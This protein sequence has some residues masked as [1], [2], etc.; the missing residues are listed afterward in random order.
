MPVR[1]GLFVWAGMILGTA[2]TMA[3]DPPA[4]LELL[5]KDQPH[6]G[7]LLAMDQSNVWLMSREGRLA[8]FELK[9]VKD[10]K[11]LAPVFQPASAGEVRDSLRREFAKEFEIAASEHYLVCAPEGK[12]RDYVKL[13]EEIYRSFRG[14]FGV[15][16][17]RVGEPEFPLVAIVF[18]DRKSFQDYCKA[19][20]VPAVS[21]LRGYY[22]RTS[23]RV[24]LYD[25]GDAQTAQSGGEPF[26]P[27]KFVD[28]TIHASLAD[29]MI[30]EA[31]HQV[32]F[33]TGLHSRIGVT[34]KW[35]VE[36]LATV[37]E[38]PGIRDS[39]SGQ[40][41]AIQRVNK[42]RYVAFQNYAQA[43][44]KPKSLADFV[45]SDKPFQA[46]ALDGYA[47]AWALSFYLIETR[48]AKYAS[49]LKAIASRDPMKD[50]PQAERLSDFQ[51]VFG[52]DLKM[53][54]AGFLRFFARLE[55]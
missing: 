12:A 46:S 5:V 26:T 50:Y 52:S 31:T 18:P 11:R 47:E 6:R 1:L 20:R 28:A 44:R 32:A 4:Y 7:K 38:A 48:P 55:D 30:H 24:A 25:P 54:E 2:A 14:Y 41:K 3:A 10:F 16:G 33:N 13:F 27:T 45:S 51:A 15:R 36:G 17:F 23:N 21:G 8:E 53:L 9:D 42:D 29:T 40:G 35:I 22:L 37:F 43:G 19:D 49:Y 34:P 39:A